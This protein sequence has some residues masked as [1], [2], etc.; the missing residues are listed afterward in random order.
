MSL[1]RSES[2]NNKLLV[3]KSG[4][5][6]DMYSNKWALGKNHTVSFKD[7]LLAINPI[8]LDSF[9]TVLSQYAE[10]YSGGHVTAIYQNFQYYIRATNSTEI[11]VYSLKNWRVT[12]DARNEWHLGSLKRFLI[13]WHDRGYQG[14][15]SEVVDYLE[16]LRLKGS[17]I[18][19]AVAN[20]CPYKGAFTDIETLALE[21][22]LIRLFKS[23]IINLTTFSYV[24]LLK[25]T[26][27][28]P[29]QL[30]HLKL[31]DIRE[32]VSYID[33][34]ENKTINYKLDIP[35]AKQAGANFREHMKTLVI[36]EE[37]YLTLSNFGIESKERLVSA[38]KI[39]LSSEE[40]KQIPLF[41]DWDLLEK[42]LRSGQFSP[43]MLNSDILH[44]STSTINNIFN[45]FSKEQSAISERTGE[46][47]H[48]SARRFRY[49]RGTNLGKKGISAQIIAE[50][51]DHSDTQCVAIYTE[52]T[53]ETATY[54]D[55]VM[56]PILAPLAAAF[57]GEIIENL[58][59]GERGNDSTAKIPNS[60]SEVVGACGSH[61]FC[62]LGYEACYLCAKFRPLLDA[63][64]EKFL[65]Q[66]YKEKESRL[67]ESKSI[68]YASTKDRLIL[69]VED[70]VAR[71]NQMKKEKG[72]EDG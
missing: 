7:D 37:L 11:D 20:R 54:I 43:D 50:A 48:I 1:K 51:L 8:V 35:R 24:M 32:E 63:P 67:K 42:F 6:F 46:I 19:E 57:K 9:R 36:N 27:R 56:G 45:G 59:E 14:I 52:N 33:G 65:I 39:Q 68:Q 60:N 47:L 4:Y 38:I 34:T 58:K 22:E 70:V 25:A 69:A 28:R 5:S 62:I 41:I 55:E 18:G 72:K 31:C 12:L 17:P 40:A 26:A 2:V 23:E 29:I 49:T 66:L 64:H 71:C 53:V 21:E 44:V 61:D 10:D 13:N 15:S 3:S 30:S 16:S